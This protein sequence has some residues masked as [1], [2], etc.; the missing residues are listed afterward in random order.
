M[1]PQETLALHD[2]EILNIEQE[3]F[4]IENNVS[5]NRHP[6]YI[7]DQVAK[8]LLI[9]V[10]H[11]VRNH[12]FLTS[13]AHGLFLLVLKEE[14]DHDH[15]RW[16]IYFVVLYLLPL[17]PLVSVVLKLQGLQLAF[18]ERRGTYGLYDLLEPFLVVHE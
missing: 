12:H 6:D 8:N 11:E 3:D 13:H 2:G 15:V 7:D 14:I 4:E 5:R 9:R 18:I 17:H 10:V 1:Q 16:V